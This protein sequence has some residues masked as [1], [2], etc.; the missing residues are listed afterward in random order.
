MTKEHIT[1]Y[2][3]NFIIM[4]IIKYIV[5]SLTVS[6]A[7]SELDRGNRKNPGYIVLRHSVHQFSSFEVLC[8]QIMGRP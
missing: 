1:I 2:F 4:N 8:L 7:H 5:F 3:K 6:Y